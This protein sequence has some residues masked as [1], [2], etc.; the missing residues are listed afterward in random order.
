MSGFALLGRAAFGVSILMVAV[1][2]AAAFVSRTGSLEAGF[3][4]ALMALLAATVP[5]FFQG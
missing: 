4:M 1:A 5:G 3:L 2:V